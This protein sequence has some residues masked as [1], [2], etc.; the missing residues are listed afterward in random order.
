[1]FKFMIAVGTLLVLPPALANAGQSIDMTGTIACVNDKW[2]E[3]EPAKGHK[4]VVYA[5]AVS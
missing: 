1:M 4:Q 2:D 3:T 5:G